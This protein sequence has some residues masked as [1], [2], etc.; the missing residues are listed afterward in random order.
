MANFNVAEVER[1]NKLAAQK[2]AERQQLIGK[3]DAAQQAF[4]QAIYA[5]EQKYGVKL[6]AENLQSEYDRVS[7]ETEKS[8]NEL[9]AMIEAI[10]NGTYQ[11]KIE[12]QKNE[13]SAQT[14]NTQEV[15][16]TP[17][18][19]VQNNPV[20][21]T[22]QSINQGYQTASNIPASPV[23]NQTQPI[24]TTAQKTEVPK[25][26]APTGF[27]VPVTSTQGIPTFGAQDKNV[28]EDISEKPVTP[29]PWGSKGIDKTF[30]D[31]LGSNGGAVKFQI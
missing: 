8:Y 28:D 5:Y 20:P 27:D 22:T 14:G 25:F 23:P 1:L 3:R 13:T 7:A 16:S 26:G 10:N 31:I 19:E 11:E 18:Q 12:A 21:N 6:T 30:E 2:N 24:S 15:Q 29:G 17:T 4:N 9:K